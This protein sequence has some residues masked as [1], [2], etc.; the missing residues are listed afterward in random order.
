MFLAGEKL[1]MTPAMLPLRPSLPA[2][3]FVVHTW[4]RHEKSVCEQLRSKQIE[5]FLP[6]YRSAKR[7]KNGQVA[8]ELP[9]FSGYLF[10]RICAENQLPVLQTPGVARFVRFGNKP[11]AVPDAEIAQLKAAVTKGIS[12]TPYPFL[13][14][15]EHVRIC[16]GPLTGLTGI[17]MRDKRGQRIILSVELIS[18]SISVELDCADVEPV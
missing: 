2:E 16:S 7:W 12:P 15:G 14:V 3:W 1:L 11:A 10:V 9:L 13:N 17:L 5:A 6:V 8:A 4:S 18:R